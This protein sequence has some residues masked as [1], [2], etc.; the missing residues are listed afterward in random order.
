MKLYKYQGAGNDFLIAD[1]RNGTIREENGVLYISKKGCESTYRIDELCDRRYSESVSC[2]VVLNSATPWTVAHQ[3]PLSMELSRQ[4]YWS[5]LPFSSPGDLPEPRIE[6]M[7][8]ALAGG[9]NEPP[10]KPLKKNR[11]II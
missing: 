7:S 2:S 10:R 3:A 9:A 11:D 8:L 1:N 5:G 6:P 4:E